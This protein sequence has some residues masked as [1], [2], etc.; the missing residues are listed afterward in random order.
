[1][2]SPQGAWAGRPGHP[3]SKS[4]YDTTHDMYSRYD[5]RYYTEFNR[6]RPPSQ[7]TSNPYATF[8]DMLKPNSYSRHDSRHWEQY[9]NAG[10]SHSSPRT[11]LKYARSTNAKRE[12]VYDPPSD[13]MTNTGSSWSGYEYPTSWQKELSVGI[14]RVLNMRGWQQE[15]LL[16]ESPALTFDLFMSPRSGSWGTLS[17]RAVQLAKYFRGQLERLSFDI[18]AVTAEGAPVDRGSLASEYI[19]CFAESVEIAKVAMK[20]LEDCPPSDRRS[21]RAALEAAIQTL[22][23]A[24]MTEAISQEISMPHTQ[25]RRELYL[26]SVESFHQLVQDFWAFDQ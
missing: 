18:P 24:E 22:R 21:E 8:S 3:G 2:L 13:R 26:A 10:G 4:R 25:N 14:V 20:K 1:M 15:K 23:G 16:G 17:F 6:G 19:F 9:F 11:A 7:M 12:R 5:P